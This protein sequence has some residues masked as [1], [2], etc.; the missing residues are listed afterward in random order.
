MK[1][2]VTKSFLPPIEEY[3]TILKKVWD[4]NQPTNRGNFKPNGS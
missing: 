3:N 4:S 2:N 1:I